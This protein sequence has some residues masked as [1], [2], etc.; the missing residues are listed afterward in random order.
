MCRNADGDGPS[1]QDEKSLFTVVSY[2]LTNGELE[3]KT[4]KTGL[5]N[6]DL[7]GSE[8]LKKDFLKHK[9]NKDLFVEPLKFR[10]VKD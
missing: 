9:D 7:N 2:Q 3:V 4:L 5:L 8:S 6:R 1:D 10:K